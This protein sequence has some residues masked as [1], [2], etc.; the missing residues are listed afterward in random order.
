MATKF[1]LDRRSPKRDGTY[2]LKLRISKGRENAMISMGVF[3]KDEQWDETACKITG[4]PNRNALNTYVA[5]RKTEVDSII[6]SLAEKGKLRIM[7]ARQ[8]KDYV[9]RTINPELKSEDNGSFAK[10]F[11]KFM[12]SKEKART[13]EIYEITLSKID[14]FTKGGFDRLDFEDI[15]KEWLMKFDNYMALTSPSKNARNINLRNIRA[16]FNEAIDNEETMFY[17][18]RKFKI[19]AQETAKRSMPV[20]QLRELFTCEVEPYQEQYRDMFKLI[21]YLIGINTADLFMLKPSDMLNGRITYQRAKTGRLYDIKLEPE[22]MEIIEKYKGERYLLNVM[23]RYGN[24]RDY[25]KRLNNNLKRIGKVSFGKHG[26]KIVTPLFPQISTYW[27]RHTW[28]T[29]AAELDIPKETIA[30]A[31]GHGGNSVTDIYIKFDRKKIDEANR[32]VIDY[33]NEE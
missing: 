20:E 7:S 1:Y 18:F 31:L 21:F 12:E 26:K 4:V 32:R 11:I 30:A 10:C 6:L 33:V 13:R 28:A 8:I 23:D 14:K 27:A 5:N 2:P 15:T 17:P 9:E 29:I 24:Y 22:A 19:K 3:L 25:A 16:V